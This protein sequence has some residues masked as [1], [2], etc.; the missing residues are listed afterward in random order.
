MNLTK[1]FRR[2][3]HLQKNWKRTYSNRATLEHVRGN[4]DNPFWT[5]Q[6]TP[7]VVDGHNGIFGNVFLNVLRQVCDD[8]LQLIAS[9]QGLA[10]SSK[11]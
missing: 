3:G 6:A 7:E 8:R 1:K 10:L 5:I 2:G 11:N 9:S 4:P